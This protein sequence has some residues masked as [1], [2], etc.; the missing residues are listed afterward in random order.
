MNPPAVVPMDLDDGED[1][2]DHRTPTPMRF[3]QHLLLPRPRLPAQPDN[4]SV[5]T[6]GDR[7]GAAPGEVRPD[8][9]PDNISVV[10]RCQTCKNDRQKVSS[11]CNA[12]LEALF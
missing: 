11:T 12:L 6:T 1:A 8:Q 2:I 3:Q 9:Q 10:T 5:A 4:T 7:L